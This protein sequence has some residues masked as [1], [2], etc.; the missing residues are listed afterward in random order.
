MAVTIEVYHQDEQWHVR[1]QGERA[2]LSNHATK[3]DAVAAGRAAA[4]RESAELVIKNLDGTIAQ[5]DSH[6]HDPRNV[7]G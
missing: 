1:R 4:E 5:K 7:P 3:D 6:G 2:P